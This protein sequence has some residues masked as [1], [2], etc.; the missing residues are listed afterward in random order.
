MILENKK[1]MNF[2][3]DFLL[4]NRKSF[5]KYGIENLFISL[6]IKNKTN[7][8]LK[9]EEIEKIVKIKEAISITFN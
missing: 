1:G 8:L 4:K 5:S 2:I 3:L 6:Y 7:F 9:K